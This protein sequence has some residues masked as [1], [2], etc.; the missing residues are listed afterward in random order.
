MGL[1]SKMKESRKKLRRKHQRRI[2]KHC[3]AEFCDMFQV[4]A[5]GP[6]ADQDADL[7]FGKIIKWLMSDL[8][9]FSGMNYEIW[10]NEI[11]TVLWKVNLMDYVEYVIKDNGDALA[12]SLI[13]S[14]VDDNIILSI[15]YEYGEILS[16]KF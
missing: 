7:E 9:F 2:V 3:F 10:A 5:D 13:T 6:S 15:I 11:K 16:T 8:P 4:D 14:E 1:Q 12:L